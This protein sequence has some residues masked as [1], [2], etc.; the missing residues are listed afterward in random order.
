ME[1]T[2]IFVHAGRQIIPQFCLGKE[3]PLI[4][5][6]PP[7]SALA[8]LVLQLFTIALARSQDL[9]LTAPSHDLSRHDR[10]V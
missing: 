7:G 8:P 1:I 10:S 2:T 6:W 9:D 4:C 5:N 3:H